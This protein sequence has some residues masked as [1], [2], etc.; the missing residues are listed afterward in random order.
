MNKKKLTNPTNPTAA[1]AVYR[2]RLWID[3]LEANGKKGRGR[4]RA[5]HGGRCCLQVAEDVAISC[6]LKITRSDASAGTPTS[7]VSNFFGW[8]DTNPNLKLPSGEFVCA[9]GV[10]DGLGK[11]HTDLKKYK[12]KGLSHKQIAEC[13]YNTFVAPKANKFSFTLKKSK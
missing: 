12:D 10:N 2:N 8:P 9:A 13:V 3:A 5:K 11:D 4:M 7:D 6:G 1:Q